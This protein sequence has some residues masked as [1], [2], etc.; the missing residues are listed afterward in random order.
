MTISVFEVNEPDDEDLD[1]V[2]PW[3]VSERVALPR[4]THL[5]NY[6]ILEARPGF[7]INSWVPYDFFC[8]ERGST[9]VNEWDYFACGTTPPGL[10][11]RRAL[12]VLRDLLKDFTPLPVSLEGFEYY[13]LRPEKTIDC[14]DIRKSIIVYYSTPPEDGPMEILRHKFRQRLLKR[15]SIFAIPQQRPLKLF[16]TELVPEIVA[17]S[18]LKGFA[19]P[20]LEG[21]GPTGLG[22]G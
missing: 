18:G 2:R 1:D 13:C 22:W 15:S 12:D 9:P 4:E 20:L 8:R 10:F 6:H 3:L 21:P 17:R 16:A 11:S 19:F 5:R 7:E 14:L